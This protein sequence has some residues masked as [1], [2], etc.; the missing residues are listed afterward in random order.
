ML[1]HVRSTEHV[2]QEDG[3]V[4][5]SNDA[6]QLCNSRFRLQFLAAILWF[7]RCIHRSISQSKGSKG[8]EHGLCTVRCN[9]LLSI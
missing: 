6:V 3:I 8:P 5:L 7:V 1:D 2:T 4:Y 9:M